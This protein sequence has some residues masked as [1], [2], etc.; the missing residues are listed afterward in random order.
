MT[1]EWDTFINSPG[2]FLSPQTLC[3]Y[4]TT[5]DCS[6]AWFWPPF[7]LYCM[8]LKKKCVSIATAVW[9]INQW[10]RRSTHTVWY[11]V[12]THCMLIKIPATV[13]GKS[14]KGFMYQK[15]VKHMCPWPLCILR[16]KFSSEHDRSISFIPS[17][18]TWFVIILISIR[19]DYDF[20][21]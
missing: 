3:A 13:H 1:E 10:Q 2:L 19:Y 15:F 12:P 8:S 6:P 17:K 18:C 21:P 7:W 4:F 11:S 9:W 14:Q 5:A 16:D 20:F